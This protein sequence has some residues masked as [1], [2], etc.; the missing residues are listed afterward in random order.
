VEDLMR[1]HGVLRRVLLIYG[2]I[3]RRVQAGLNFPMQTLSAAAGI[4]HDFVENYHEQVEEEQVFPYF[5]RAGRMV[6]LVKV[7]RQQHQAGRSICKPRP[8]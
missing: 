4:I 5:E 1:E 7:L 6:P 2:E 3:D 8:G